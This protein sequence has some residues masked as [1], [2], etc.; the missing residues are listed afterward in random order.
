MSFSEG[1]LIMSMFCCTGQKAF[2]CDL[3]AWLCSRTSIHK[4]TRDLAELGVQYLGLCCGNRAHFTR[5]MAEE[6]GREPPASR[7][8]PDMSQHL[9]SLS[10]KDH[11]HSATS[12]IHNQAMED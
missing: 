3:D 9:S 6:L 8:S 7:Y 1:L 4:L 11:S 2:P 5:A 10:D 12:F